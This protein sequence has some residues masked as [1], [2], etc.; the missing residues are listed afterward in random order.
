MTVWIK[1]WQWIVSRRRKRSSELLVGRTREKKLITFPVPDFPLFFTTRTKF[2]ILFF[3]RSHFVLRNIKKTTF[4]LKDTSSTSSTS[5]SGDSTATTP[6]PATMASS[7][8][9]GASS[10]TPS[11][12]STAAAGKSSKYL[13]V[14]KKGNLNQIKLL[15]SSYSCTQVM[16]MHKSQKNPEAGLTFTCKTHQK[17]CSTKK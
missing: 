16:R 14:D 2:S 5:S 10:Q 12:T 11:P 4:M 15:L 1:L 6:P 7:T 8:S 9:T 13:K 3:G 17:K